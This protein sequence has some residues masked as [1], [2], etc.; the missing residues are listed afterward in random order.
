LGTNY[1]SN[2]T[3]NGIHNI[4]GVGNTF[5]NGDSFTYQ[6]DEDPDYMVDVLSADEG[7]FYFTCQNDIVRSV[8]Y[9]E[10]SYR[11]ICTSSIFGAMADAE[12]SSTKANLMA[13]YF[14]F[15]SNDPDPHIWASTDELDFGTQYLSYPATISLNIRNLGYVDLNVTYIDIIGEGFSYA[16]V[17]SFSLG[18]G[19]TAEIEIIFTALNSGT[20]SGTLSIESN[21]PDQNPLLINLSGE[22]VLPP[23]IDVTPEELI[24]IV[25]PGDIDFDILTIFNN[26]ASDLTYAISATETTSG[27]CSTNPFQPV[28]RGSTVPGVLNRDNSS[29]YPA[30]LELLTSLRDSVVI[31]S[32]DMESGINGW[33]TEMYGGAP[34]DLWHQS[35]LNCNSPTHSWWC[36]IEGSTNYA[37]GSRINTAVISPVIDLTVIDTTVTLQFFENYVTEAGWDFCMVD[38]TTDGGTSWTSLRGNA[39]NAPSGNS[40]GWIT[41]ILDLTQF[42]GNEIRI[43]FYF[44]TTDS[45]NNNTSG[46][47]FDDVLVYFEGVPWL[48]IYPNSGTIL[49]GQSANITVTYDASNLVEGEYTANITISS[50]DPAEPEVIIPVTLT[51]GYVNAEQEIIP[52]VTNLQGNYPNPFN[53]AT[54]I[55][56]SVAQTS[57]FVNLEVFNI[58]GQ[59]VKTL[60]DE[61]LP[62][63]QHSVIWNGKDENGKPVSSG[64]YFYKMKAGS[65]LSS[66]KMI[67]LK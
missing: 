47:F 20:F 25:P 51:V 48:P 24:A 35:E 64:V 7:T 21:D 19:E 12:G 8:Y 67:L 65:Y 44:D 33:T 2:G 42:I 5:T 30:Y 57:S 55:S 29:T 14:S 6:F 46:W 15:L 4:I 62:A 23:E 66:K 56:F 27:S 10:G 50:N 61:I 58:K 34:D 22:C 54:T 3:T 13:R 38:V 43:R 63:D 18:W 36:G 32:D 17:P 28:K 52:I 60:I 31:F 9:D 40:G 41:T 45:I 26:G 11:V 37:T 39:G 49:A 16:G 59:K 1:I 53:P